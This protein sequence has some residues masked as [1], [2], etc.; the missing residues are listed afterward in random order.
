MVCQ[1]VYQS[2]TCIWIISNLHI[3]HLWKWNQRGFKSALQTIFQDL[4]VRYLMYIAHVFNHS[5]FPLES[6]TFTHMT[7]T[8]ACYVILWKLSIGHKQ[9]G[10]TTALYIYIDCL[11]LSYSTYYMIWFICIYIYIQQLHICIGTYQNT[12]I[13]I[14]MLLHYQYVYI[15]IYIYT[16]I[17]IFM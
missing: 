9:C 5:H 13:Y 2:V 1:K 6:H 3:L 4:I 7:K 15:R 10:W 8:A 12:H 11:I 17:D 16:Y 14:Y